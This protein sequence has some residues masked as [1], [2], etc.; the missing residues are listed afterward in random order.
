MERS[1]SQRD[2]RV[3]RLSK[4]PYSRPEPSRLRKSA[5]MTPLAT[6]KSI[7]NYVSSPFTKTSSP[8]VLPTHRIDIDQDQDQDIRSES[9]S[10]DEWNGE[11]P[12]TMN[13]QDLFTLA[14]AAGRDGEEF[15]KRAAA[16]RAKGEIPGGKRQLARLGVE[17]HSSSESLEPPTPTA[18]GHFN[19]LKSSPSMPILS[20]SSKSQSAT[21]SLQIPQP[22]S[23]R[24][25]T[26][27]RARSSLS[28][29]HKNS[30]QLPSPQFSTPTATP[31][32]VTQALSSSASSVALT[33]FLEAK[34]GQQMTI[35][36]F[37]VIETLTDNMKAESHVGSPTK[38][39]S[40]YQQQQQKTYGGWAAG[41]Y[42]SGIKSSISFNSNLSTPAK[43]SNGNGNGNLAS[44]PGKVFSLGTQPT[45]SPA[46][47]S[48]GP[49]RQRY[50]GPGMSPRR[51][52]PQPKKST[53]KPLFNFGTAE[54]DDSTSTGKKRKVDGEEE[55]M[56]LDSNSNASLY[57]SSSTS[58][59]G[60][61]SSVSMP[62]FSAFNN[63][64]GKNRLSS[65]SS[66]IH[67]PAKP[68]PLSRNVSS[69]SSSS[70]TPIDEKAKRRAEAEAAGKKRAA[71]IIMDIIDEEIGPVIPTR[72][73]EPVIFNPY[74]RTSLNPT[75]IPAVPT[76]LPSTSF[77][78]TTP[79]KS[80]LKSSISSNSSPGR[81]TPTRGAAAKLEL[82]KEAMKGSKPLTTIERIQ[83]V[84][85]WERGGK[86][87]SSI[88]RN[89]TPITDD[90]IIEI[91]D[92]IEG[93]Q[94]SSSK[95]ASPAPESSTN[96]ASSP[97]P[98]LQSASSKIPA[99]ETFKPFEPPSITFNS[100]P[101]PETQPV[102][103]IG[104]FDSPTR[105]SII[106]SSS[107]SSNPIPKPTFSFGKPSAAAATL[108]SE[109]EKPEEVSTTQT[110]E[111][112]LES[113][114]LDINKVYLSAKDSALKIAK[115]ALPFFTFTLPPRPFESQNQ[116][117]K[118]VLE[119][120]KNKPQS[121]FT[122][123][124]PSLDANITTSSQLAPPAKDWECGLCML[125]N[126]ASATEK[127]TIC[128]APKPPTV[129]V[130]SSAPSFGF[131]PKATPASTGA[132]KEWECS[133][134]ML[135]N[136][137]SATE[138][139]TICEAPKPASTS[140]PKPSTQNTFGGFTG[141]GSGFQPQTSSNQ[142]TCS[143]C[144]LKNPD[145]AKDKCTVC[146]EPR[147]GSKPKPP[148]STPQNNFGGF[149]GFGSG[150]QPQS[151]SDQ[152]TCT[153]CMLKNPDSV[154]D[155]CTICE[156]PRP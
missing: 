150:F 81:R 47:A 123:T 28:S 135:K 126:P 86:S 137:A 141:F 75:P 18:P 145:S 31:I 21:S 9:G 19:F 12:S 23:N 27:K 55:I 103:S 85:P 125:K 72:K 122:F 84:K 102:P 53:L 108:T 4:T 38:S 5:S 40:F 109:S 25:D 10:E 45:F 146:E 63:E 127:C 39:E 7:V 2:L 59:K 154:K 60:L 97:P 87:S 70:N 61:S 56:D 153:V 90:D 11:A 156:S 143:V 37:R 134:C 78:G 66:S 20:T 131:T 41:T 116:P 48:S 142:W 29:E 44:T 36:D 42:S 71:E 15:E 33:A 112:K 151:S 26:I 24:F 82:H 64:K 76:S 16:W 139:C 91:D 43:Q 121:T 124:L 62:S 14:S 93:S 130:S 8:S 147:P 79:R 107:S 114:K 68:S 133:L 136:P 1:S 100:R 88:S 111:T 105:D 101:P 117:K 89:E 83:G 110:K 46:V 128:E 138:K 155:K 65:L 94:A 77:A 92:L 99:A 30:Q 35:E 74:D 67:T 129:P 113:N 80:L 73:A 50:L 144:M 51:M 69:P 49:Y 54:E 6:L 149:T 118:E 32:P 132:G 148:T 17:A 106:A 34:K 120:A 115:P 152:W 13:G 104:S 58:T 52:F 119:Q 95:A 98:K 3:E 57:L 140:M 22:K 96:K